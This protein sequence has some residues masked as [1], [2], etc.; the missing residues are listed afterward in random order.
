M[1]DLR[2]THNG[3]TNCNP[4]TSTHTSNSHPQARRIRDRDRPQSFRISTPCRRKSKTWVWALRK[5]PDA[6]RTHFQRLLES[7][8]EGVSAFA[9][10]LWSGTVAAQPAAA[11][12]LNIGMN[13]YSPTGECAIHI[14]ANTRRVWATRNVFNALL[15]AFP[16][17]TYCSFTHSCMCGHLMHSS[18]TMVGVHWATDAFLG[19]LFV[20]AAVLARNSHVVHFN[21]LGVLLLL[22]YCDHVLLA[23]GAGY[24]Y[25]VFDAPIMLLITWRCLARLLSARVVNTNY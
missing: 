8:S 18:P 20:L 23:N 22:I 3:K 13:P 15:L 2:E 5:I 4:E 12:R 10:K 7:Q 14:D 9:E 11:I 21:T 17:F 19:G 6:N 24:L 16:L 25:I 1:I